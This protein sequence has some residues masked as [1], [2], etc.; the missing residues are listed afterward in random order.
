MAAGPCN[1]GFHYVRLGPRSERLERAPRH[2]SKRIVLRTSQQAVSGQSSKF[3]ASLARSECRSVLRHRNVRA[4]R[5]ETVGTRICCSPTACAGVAPPL[6]DASVQ[7]PPTRACVE[8]RQENTVKP[9]GPIEGFAR[10]IVDCTFDTPAGCITIP[11]GPDWRGLDPGG[12][13]TA[14]ASC[15]SGAAAGGASARPRDPARVRSRRRP[16][17]PCRRRRARPR[18][19]AAHRVQPSRRREACAR[20]GR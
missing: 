18:S 19:A 5:R 13:E 10:P 14:C 15:F 2:P 3:N 1:Q 9:R 20:G 16:R 17:G 11:S 7:A 6:P 4:C 8:S 12:G